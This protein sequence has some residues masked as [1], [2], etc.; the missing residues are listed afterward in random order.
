[1][2]KINKMIQR[3]QSLYLFAGI[4]LSVAI[5][6][7]GVFVVHQGSDFIILGA[8]GIKEGGLLIDNVIMLPLG[9]LAAI[10]I[11]VEIFAISQF[12]NRSLQSN[13]VKL[14]M[15]LAV[16]MFGWIGFQYYILMNLDVNVN[17]IMGILHSPM[18]LFAGILSLRG[19][20][21][22]EALVKSVD[23]LR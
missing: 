7:S 10:N 23:R 1:M 3:I 14:S 2:A 13:L 19:I 18:I 17:P 5:M 20:N 21:K 16:L 6:F 8:F 4:V 11:G 22:D 12:K 15:F 9:I